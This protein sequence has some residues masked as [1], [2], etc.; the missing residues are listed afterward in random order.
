MSG[1]AAGLFMSPNTVGIMNSLPARERGA[2]S[3]IRATFINTGNVLSMGV[4]FTLM[5]VGISGKLPGALFSGL[6][7]Q[8]VPAQSASQI[9]HLP[10]A[11]SLFAA[12]LRLQ[13]A[14]YHDPASSPC[15]SAR[16]HC[17]SHHRHDL[18]PQLI[19]PAFQQGLRVIFGVGLVLCLIA[20]GASWLR[21]TE[22]HA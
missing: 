3:G 11:T 2:D 10:A 18:L 13:P 22:V 6:T 17:R 4:F 7:A 19:S 5:I 20:A 12:L 16:R 1:L 8:G 14:W 15:G 21:G 9:S